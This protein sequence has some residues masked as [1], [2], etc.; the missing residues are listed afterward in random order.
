MF[1]LIDF[2]FWFFFVRG[3]CKFCV[4][5]VW[6][7]SDE[8]SFSFRTAKRGILLS[9]NRSI[10]VPV[11]AVLLNWF[12]YGKKHTK[13]PNCKLNLIYRANCNSLVLNW[14]QE[15][16]ARHIRVMTS[17][18]THVFHVSILFT[19]FQPVLI[20]KPCTSCTLLTPTSTST[21][22][23]TNLPPF[24]A[25]L[26]CSAGAGGAGR[27]S[28]ALCLIFDKKK[29]KMCYEVVIIALFMLIDGNAN[30]LLLFFPPIL[31]DTVK[32]SVLSP[33]TQK[34][35]KWLNQLAWLGRCFVS[36][37]LVLLFF[38]SFPPLI[39]TVSPECT[40]LF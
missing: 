34:C 29:K 37:L 31:P 18:L 25:K 24:V 33:C 16:S 1:V 36:F 11:L 28:V 2:C 35:K 13:N 22:T 27:Q 14:L 26:F 40:V 21:T 39:A 23:K 7:L 17:S 4:M 15:Q 20:N 38:T 12:L 9:E 8:T 32:N 6:F 3:E 19:A 10:G 30:M 5:A